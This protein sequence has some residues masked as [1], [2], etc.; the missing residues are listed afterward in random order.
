MISTTKRSLQAKELSYPNQKSEA[1][2]FSKRKLFKSF[3]ALSKSFLR[4]LSFKTSFKA[5]ALIFEL[6]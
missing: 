6:K 2:S 1:E 5:R 3:D 4:I